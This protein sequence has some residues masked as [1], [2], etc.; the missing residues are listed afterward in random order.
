MFMLYRTSMGAYMLFR[1]GGD[2]AMA[3]GSRD[4]KVLS[5]APRHMAEVEVEVES[6]AV[7]AAI[8]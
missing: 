4:H 1:P 6:T 5:S 8:S 7:R 3:D 2:N